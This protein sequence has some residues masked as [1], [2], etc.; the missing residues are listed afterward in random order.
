[1]RAAHSRCSIVALV[2]AA[3]VLLAAVCSAEAKTVAVI[4]GGM[5]AAASAKYLR[6]LM[7]DV[8]IAVF[9]MADEVGGR[10][11]DVDVG[12]RRLETGAGIVY[13][14]NVYMVEAANELGLTKVK[15]N[16]PWLGKLPQ[17]G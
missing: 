7:P 8:D 2:A 6:E 9:E 16:S 10:T 11:A 4:G 15:L 3:L 17:E 12:E 1:M 13:D 5:T 14:G